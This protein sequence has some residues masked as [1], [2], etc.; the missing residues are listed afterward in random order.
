MIPGTWI[1]YM[2][3]GVVILVSLFTF[4]GNADAEP[5]V[6]EIRAIART[7]SAAAASGDVDTIA[8][9]YAP[10]ALLLPPNGAV[11]AGR[12]S[13]RAANAGNQA[14]GA[15]TLVFDQLRVSGDEQ[16][17]T[18]IWTWTLTIAPEGRSPVAA[19]GRSMV[20]FERG[21]AGGRSCSTCSRRIDRTA[22][23]CSSCSITHTPHARF[24]SG[25]RRRSPRSPCW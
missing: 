15:N 22:P 1:R 3:S 5:P 14:A 11:V 6:E 13:I 4:A 16:R 25:S 9:L 10:N 7:M 17:A 23:D 24:P 21:D 18:A 12:D 20:Y 19:Q 8:G 2:G